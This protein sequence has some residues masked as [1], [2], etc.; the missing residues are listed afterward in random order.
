MEELLSQLQTLAKPL[1][2]GEQTLVKP[3]TLEEQYTKHVPLPPSLPL[4]F[5][6]DTHLWH[7]TE[8]KSGLDPSGDAA[9]VVSDKGTAVVPDKD[10]TMAHVPLAP[11]SALPHPLF[12]GMSFVHQQLATCQGLSRMQTPRGTREPVTFLWLLADEYATDPLLLAGLSYWC[13]VWAHQTRH[14]VVS[15]TCPLGPA[16][17]V[18]GGVHWIRWRHNCKALKASLNVLGKSKADVVWASAS[19]AAPDDLQRLCTDLGAT[20]AVVYRPQADWI[21]HGFLQ[22]F[23]RHGHLVFPHFTL[24]DAHEGWVVDG[25]LPSDA[26]V[27][28]WGKD[29]CPQCV[30]L[31]KRSATS[32]LQHKTYN[33]L[34]QAWRI[35]TP[36]DEQWKT[37]LTLPFADASHMMLLSSS[38]R[39]WPH[40]SPAQQK[41]WMETVALCIRPNRH[42]KKW[43]RHDHALHQRYGSV[44]TTTL[45]PDYITT[46]PLV[47]TLAKWSSSSKGGPRGL[48]GPTSHRAHAQP[49]CELALS[50]ETLR[51]VWKAG[52]SMAFV[53]PAQG[54]WCAVL[55]YDGVCRFLW[56]DEQWT[57]DV[58]DKSNRWKCTSHFCPWYETAQQTRTSVHHFGWD[59]LPDR[60]GLVGVLSASTGSF[61]ALDAFLLPDQELLF[62][63]E[64]YGSRR[65]TLE[66]FV[67]GLA[68]PFVT[69]PVALD[70]TQ[71]TDIVQRATQDPDASF[72]FTLFVMTG[73]APFAGFHGGPNM[74]MR[75]AWPCS[76][77]D[78]Q[79]YQTWDKERQAFESR[80]RHRQDHDDDKRV[81]TRKPYRPTPGSV[82]FTEPLTSALHSGP[83][84]DEEY[85]PT[86]PSLSSSP[87]LMPTSPPYNPTSP[88][89]SSTT[90]SYHPS[91][92]G[93]VGAHASSPLATPTS[94][95]YAP[96]PLDCPTAP[97]REFSD[98]P[99]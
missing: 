29:G 22:R 94:P 2:R 78:V 41:S 51:G 46:E 98:W 54:C 77:E 69:C 81:H 17:A 43:A 11:F 52:V 44:D 57:R 10:K 14:I 68:H 95:H 83:S 31:G 56:P 58:E 66:T 79:L 47:D 50:V 89:A 16:T 73:S 42:W 28:D 72:P 4:Y 84:Y 96:L 8:C 71:T 15:S 60:T 92:P 39:H 25:P 37:W 36:L 90:P 70:E 13:T 32:E 38:Y 87:P 67:Q 30:P 61:A 7:E 5:V 76:A 65:R 82:V 63:T 62:W 85:S 80:R 48:H 33:D 21:A 9:D 24:K 93:A 26:W 74:W 75:W 91:S 35:P 19:C 23:Q 20:T 49:Q 99:S 64:P 40:V 3:L 97:S 45:R 12:F 55:K 18:T 34:R 6:H 53:A 1:T 27:Q 59:H 86:R 88:V